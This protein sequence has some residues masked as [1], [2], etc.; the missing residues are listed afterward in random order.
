MSFLHGL[1]AG[2][3]F[4]RSYIGITV[5]RGKFFQIP[6]A[7]LPN[8]AA[9]RGKF[10]TYSNSFSMASE[11]D[12]ICSMQIQSVYQINW[13]YFRQ[14]QLNIFSIPPVK[15]RVTVMYFM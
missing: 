2:V 4:V 13:Q 15:A 8:S 5:F 11:P 9:H 6:R 12:Q 7:S 1:L 3:Y 14:V 10:T